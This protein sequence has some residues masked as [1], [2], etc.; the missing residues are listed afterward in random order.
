MGA[1]A[2]QKNGPDD[3]ENIGTKD[4][5]LEDCGARAHRCPAPFEILPL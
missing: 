2:G 4:Q 3:T 1:V 5:T